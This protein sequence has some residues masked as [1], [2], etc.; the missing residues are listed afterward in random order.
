MFRSALPDRGVKPPPP[1]T[2]PV[3][4]S[5]YIIAFTQG[6]AG[7]SLCWP[8]RSLTGSQRGSVTSSWREEWRTDK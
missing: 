4:L 6:S 7:Q 8:E 2:I 3:Y 1:I 5:P